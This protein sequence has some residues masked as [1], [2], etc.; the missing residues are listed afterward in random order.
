M[1]SAR[2]VPIYAR[3]DG[4]I[5]SL[6]VGCARRTQ[7]TRRIR[8]RRNRGHV[9]LARV[10]FICH[11]WSFNARLQMGGRGSVHRRRRTGRGPRRR[12]QRLAV[13]RRPRAV[14]GRP[15]RRQR[16]QRVRAGGNDRAC[17]QRDFAPARDDRRP[18]GAARRSRRISITSSTR[19][20]RSTVA[21]RCGIRGRVDDDRLTTAGG[22]R[23][24]RFPLS[25][26]ADRR[27]VG[28]MV[29]R[30]QRNRRVARGRRQARERCALADRS[31]W[32]AAPT[33]PRRSLRSR[34]DLTGGRSATSISR[35]GCRRWDS[36]ACRSPDA[37]SGN[38]TV[39]GR[40]PLVEFA[41]KR[42]DRQR[43]RSGR[44]R[45]IPPKRRC[46]RSVPRIAVE[47]RRAGHAG[48]IGNGDGIA[49]DAAARSARSAGPR[50]DRRP[51]A[52]GLS[53]RARKDSGDRGV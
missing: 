7:S 44:S 29:E 34:Y 47:R 48:L 3:V 43:A 13:R 4:S 46:I 2:S 37:P 12:S 23:H 20:I 14:G 39:R 33:S 50:R 18:C 24:R 31:D 19:A 1:W 9:T 11:R 42:R 51:A 40:F 41:R 32:R 16:S 25:Q 28:G 5:G 53:T 8:P 17:I 38:A 52:P 10:S 49:R 6:D 15:A 36:Q 45:S 22:H 35:F 21:G 26:P 30:A 27:Y